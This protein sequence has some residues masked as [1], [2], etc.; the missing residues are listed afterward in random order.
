MFHICVQR[1]DV[2]NNLEKFQKTN[3][4][5]INNLEKQNISNL[6]KIIEKVI[7]IYNIK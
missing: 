2:T 3:N 1:F 4:Q 6:I 7:E 5:I